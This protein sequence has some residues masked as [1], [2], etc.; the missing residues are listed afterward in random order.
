MNYPNFGRVQFDNLCRRFACF[1]FL[2]RAVVLV[3]GYWSR[4]VLTGLHSRKDHRPR[5]HVNEA[6]GIKKAL[7]G[8]NKGGAV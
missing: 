1:V 5:K 4:E 6:E 2:W 3:V 7:L 8:K